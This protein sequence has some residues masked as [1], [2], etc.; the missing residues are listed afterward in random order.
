MTQDDKQNILIDENIQSIDHLT[1]FSSCEECDTLYLKVPLEK[2]EKACCVCCGAEIYSD[3]KP[4]NT[5]ISLT[6]TAFII[7][8]VANSFPIIKIEIQGHSIQ[9]TLLGAAWTMFQIDRA[10]VGIILIITTFAVP[11][12]NLILL[13]YVFLSVGWLNRRPYFMV[14]AL[15]T[16]YLFR[17]W[18]MVEVFLIGILVTLVK[19]VSMVLVIPEVALWAFG[20][21]SIFM[22]YLNAIKV[23]DTWDAID[24]YLS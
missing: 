12:V 13:M 8:I 16:L 20:L 15:R 4:F 7:F 1:Q 24:R 17:M 2:G 10:A 21:L 3:I 5:M 19:L 11:L 18:A 22:V 14:F 9:T 23:Q 6:I